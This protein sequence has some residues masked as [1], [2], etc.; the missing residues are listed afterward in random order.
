VSTQPPLNT[1]I[2]IAA[3][4]VACVLL[5][6]FIRSRIAPSN[7]A[8]ANEIPAILEQLQ[9]GEGDP[10]FAVF[11]FVPAD[12]KDGEP[13]NLQYSVEKGVVG[14]DWLLVSPRNIADRVAIAEFAKPLGYVL[15]EHATNAVSYLRVEGPWVAQLGI[16]VIRDLYKIH[17]DAK[18]DLLV[19][20]F[21]W[22]PPRTAA[23]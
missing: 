11:M 3:A 7:R 1:L 21:D 9:L 4:A 17:A 16:R 19:E 15:V 5:V 6:L 22:P 20:G 14:F 2:V 10:R 23:S 18:L 12:S 13:V 8:S